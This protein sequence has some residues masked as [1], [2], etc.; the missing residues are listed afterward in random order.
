MK[1][2]DASCAA[3]DL[4]SQT[5]RW[6]PAMAPAKSQAEGGKAVLAE[7]CRLNW[8]PWYSLAGRRGY[9]ADDA[10]DLMPRFSL[11]AATADARRGKP[12]TFDPLQILLEIGESEGMPSA[13][14]A[15]NE[16]G[17]AFAGVKT[18]I[19]RTRKTACCYFAW[20]SVGRYRISWRSTK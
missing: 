14:G 15:G 1:P 8:N 11:H 3:A 16:L 20:R 19:H 2:D 12:L 7:L 13:E 4:K 17:I 10:Q 5:I 6:A 18:L 9:S